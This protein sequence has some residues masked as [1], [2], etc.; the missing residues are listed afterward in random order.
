ML[1]KKL[2]DYIIEVK[3]EFM[4]RRGKIFIVK[5]REKRSMWVYRRINKERVY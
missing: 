1:T 3:K 5:G 2:W 4:P